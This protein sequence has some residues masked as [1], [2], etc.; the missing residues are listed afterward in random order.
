M[1]DP[2]ISIWCSLLGDKPQTLLASRK[3]L[4]LC[5]FNPF[6]GVSAWTLCKLISFCIYA[7]WFLFQ[8][9]FISCSLHQFKYFTD[10]LFYIST[11]VLPV[12]PHFWWKENETLLISLC[13]FVPQ[14]GKRTAADLHCLVSDRDLT[15]C[16]RTLQQSRLSATHGRYRPAAIKSARL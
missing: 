8:M 1:V 9:S 6:A 11:L 5:S 7:F 4:N 16:P 14:G 12:S 2:Y 13:F 15:S 10:F 3:I